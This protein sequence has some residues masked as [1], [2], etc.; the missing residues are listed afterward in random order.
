MT[1]V[2][3]SGRTRAV[4]FW[5]EVPEMPRNIGAGDRIRV[6]MVAPPWFSIP[7]RA[8]G[9]IEEVVGDL[10]RALI[11]RGHEVT[12]VGAGRDGTPARFLRTYKEP[13]SSQLG[14]PLPEVVHAAAAAQ[15]LADLDVDV[16]HDHTLAGPL[17]AAS[18]DVPTVATAHGP[19]DGEAGDYY[20]QLGGAVSLVA[21][22]A[23]Q[24]ATAPDL[25]WVGTV[26]NGVDLAS[27]PFQEEKEDWVLFIGRFNPDKGAHLAIDA[28]RAAR[29]P[30][31]LAGKVN[32]PAEEE[33]FEQAIRPYLGTDVAYVGEVDA[34][35]KRELYA[36]A[37][38]LVFPVRWPEPFGM[39]MIEAM[40]CG[41][42]VVAL[43]SG[44]VPEVVVDG[45]TGYICASTTELPVAIE[46]AG[47]LRP[48]ACRAHVAEHFD[49]S[50]VADG[51]ENVYRQVIA[52]GH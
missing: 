47:R 12:L 42:P 5:R 40:A 36:K 50:V 16:V 1:T 48:A 45:T 13:P 24:R 46:K 27:F 17:T 49:L 14:E 44:S 32:E 20:R 10:T 34:A 4:I 8:Y 21:I 29:R 41:T 6:A 18:R 2:C 3:V 37:A 35:G 22:S 11:A 15:L 30:I 39:V 38:C 51:Y 43:N 28:A 7:P 31:V 9:G 33:Y 23:A 25:N 52:A 26:H 19:V